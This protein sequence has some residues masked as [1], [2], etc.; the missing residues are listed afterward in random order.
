MK[1]ISLMQPFASFLVS[2]KKLYETRKW[3][4][5][6]RGQLAIHASR[7]TTEEILTYA[8]REPYA[9]V[10]KE[11]GYKDIYSMPRGLVLGYVTLL[12]CI[13]ATVL[14]LFKLSEWEL[15]VGDFREGRFAWKLENPTPFPTPFPA[16]GR[17]SLYDIQLPQE[18]SGHVFLPFLPRELLP[19]N[20]W[21]QERWTLT[22]DE[23]EEKQPP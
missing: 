21:P 6:H 2:G 13:P 16:L 15:S 14:D 3:A 4:P 7:R 18:P 9:S 11:L 12:D 17:P 22:E 1:C 5:K 19:D 10:I 23:H 8:R 20:S